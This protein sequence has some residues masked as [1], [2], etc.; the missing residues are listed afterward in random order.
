MNSRH[1]GYTPFCK[2]VN[3]APK[4]KNRFKNTLQAEIIGKECISQKMLKELDI[5]RVLQ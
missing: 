4:P 1:L 3:S 5:T 2:N